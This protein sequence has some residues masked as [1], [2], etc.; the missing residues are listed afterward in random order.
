M[1]ILISWEI[2]LKTLIN[3]IRILILPMYTGERKFKGTI[4]IFIF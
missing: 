3:T 4:I 2:T 1:K